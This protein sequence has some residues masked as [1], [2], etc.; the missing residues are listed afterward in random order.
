MWSSCWIDAMKYEH[1]RQK[2]IRVQR[3]I[4]IRMAKAYCTTSSEALCVLKGMTPK[5]I[6]T[7]EAVKQYSI[8]KRKGS[9]IHV[10]D[11]DMELKDWPHP[12]DA[13]KIREV[14]G[15]KE[16]TVQAYTDGSKYEQGVRSGAAVFIGKE[17]VAQIKL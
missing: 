6:K 1:S 2:N 7:E 3:L 8:R 9:Q 17:I 5:I 12:A 16:T 4:N 13:V 10:F 14:K 11:K 15:Y